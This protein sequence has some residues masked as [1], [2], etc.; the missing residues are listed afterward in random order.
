VTKQSVFSAMENSEDKQK[1][2]KSVQKIS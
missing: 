2:P 1:V